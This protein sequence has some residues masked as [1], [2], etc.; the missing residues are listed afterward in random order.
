MNGPAKNRLHGY[1]A[2]W[3]SMLVET[4][5]ATKEE[6]EAAQARVMRDALEQLEK[7]KERKKRRGSRRHKR[8]EE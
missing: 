4:G 2:G 5:L 7:E 8:D 3:L 1:E 6:A